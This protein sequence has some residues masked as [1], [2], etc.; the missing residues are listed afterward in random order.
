[1]TAM[2]CRFATTMQ[3]QYPYQQVPQ[4]HTMG[5]ISLILGILGLVGILPII[6]SVA[7]IITGNMA[8]KDIAANPAMYTGAGL[9]SAG[10]IMGWIGVG[11]MAIG[12]LCG[13]VWLVFFGGLALL[14]GTDVSSLLPALTALV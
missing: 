9:A 11:F 6:G 4:N 7:A 12:C 13:I 10:V 2:H 5:I 14:S 1:M 8:K 3:Q